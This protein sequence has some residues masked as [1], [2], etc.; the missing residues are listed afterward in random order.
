M[1]KYTCLRASVCLAECDDPHG[2]LNL[3]TFLNNSFTGLIFIQQIFI[4]TT[5]IA[6]IIT[7]E[8]C[9]YFK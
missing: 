1:C 3:V 2:K 8:T 4:N 6:I 9:F 7:I 5:I